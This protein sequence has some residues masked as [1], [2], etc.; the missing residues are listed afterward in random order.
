MSRF[1]PASSTATKPAPLLSAQGPPATK[2]PAA[3]TFPAKANGPRAD[4]PT[5]S[6]RA[7]ELAKRLPLEQASA[8]RS[9]I[10]PELRSDLFDESVWAEPRAGPAEV[11]AALAAVR[12]HWPDRTSPAPAAR[13]A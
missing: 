5:P 10:P 11:L 6:A 9:A 7:V 4:P 1:V 12:D 3:G 8:A 2:A 13:R